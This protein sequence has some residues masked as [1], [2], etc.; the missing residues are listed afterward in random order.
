MSRSRQPPGSY[1]AMH[2]SP[3]V[4]RLLHRPDLD[5]DHVL[6]KAEKLTDSEYF[7]II[8]NP[9][10]A[11]LGSHGRLVADEDWV[12]HCLEVLKIY[13]TEDLLE[14]FLHILVTMSSCL[15]LN[16]DAASAVLGDYPKPTTTLKVPFPNVVIPTQ[17]APDEW[18]EEMVRTIMC[19]PTYVGLPPFPPHVS[20]SHWIKAN[21]RV[22]KHQDMTVPQ[23]LVNMLSTLKSTYSFPGG[24]EPAIP[25][26]YEEE[27]IS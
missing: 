2:V 26:G 21:S 8:A 10:I 14:G 16:H 9:F 27:D 4:M 24:P 23:F 3:Y 20:I 17:K 25:P 22:I 19:N 1:P 15:F 18:N 12:D 13:R 7:A 11:G 6:Q 5:F